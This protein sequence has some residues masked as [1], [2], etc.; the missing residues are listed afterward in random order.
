[1]SAIASPPSLTAHADVLGLDIAAPTGRLATARRAARFVSELAAERDDVVLVETAARVDLGDVDDQ[2]VGEVLSQAGR[3]SAELAQGHQWPLLQ[4]IAARAAHDARAKA[5]IEQLRDVARRE[6]H[7]QDLVDALQAASAASAALLAAEQPT[8][9]APVDP[10]VTP[11]VVTPPE[12]Q[13]PP[14]NPP[15][16][17]PVRPPVDADPALVPVGDGR[18]VEPGGSGGSGNGSGA[19]G[20]SAVPQRREVTDEATW[21]KVAAEIAAEVAT[22]RRVTVT[23]EI[24]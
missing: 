5:I 15:V 12:G 4:A 11:P 9:P 10:L 21:E 20:L 1:M 24:R 22:G 8:K 13:T 16:I 19:G 3:I 7:G 17:P 6:Q 23:W 2:A 18:G 14:A